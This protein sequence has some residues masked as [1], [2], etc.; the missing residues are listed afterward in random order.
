M[1]IVLVLGGGCVC[2]TSHHDFSP[3]YT[4]ANHVGAP[5]LT[6]IRRVVVLPTWTGT[7]ASRSTAVELDAI[8]LTVL[9][10]QNRFEVVA[11]GREECRVRFHT[12]SL[13]S[14]AALPADF[15]A[16][17]QREFAADAVLFVD[18]TA[19]SGYRPL[20]I[21]LR[22]KLATIEDSWLLWSFDEVFS[23]ANPAVANSARR[24]VLRLDPGGGPAEA[25]SVVLHSPGQ[26]ADYAAS[27][28]FAT[29]PPVW[30][31]ATLT[32]P[33]AATGLTGRR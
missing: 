9:R 31:A 26:F 13:A 14:W 32:Q 18:L 28:M 27:T 22:A 2:P 1:T 16:R 33:A 4:P 8:L 25:G 11:V 29:L 3:F 30:T 23:A 20:T 6:G 17:L 5:G 24:H 10:Q 7:V 21:G 15:M 12:E 19:Y